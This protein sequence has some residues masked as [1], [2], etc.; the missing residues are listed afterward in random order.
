MNT[1]NVPPDPKVGNPFL[2][3]LRQRYLAM[4]QSADPLDQAVAQQQL[5]IL[6][7][8]KTSPRPTDTDDRGAELL[9]LIQQRVGP[10]RARPGGQFNGP[11]AFHESRS[12]T[13]LVVWPDSGRWWCSS[14]HRSG[15]LVRWIAE[16]EGISERE[17]RAR[18]GLPA[19]VVPPRRRLEA[20]RYG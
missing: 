8:P 16:T 7:A 11:C 17:A 3:A 2:T 5:A 15:D 10:L 19:R 18:L 9:A 13:C 1:S 20:V 6:N 12:G 14:C 4:L